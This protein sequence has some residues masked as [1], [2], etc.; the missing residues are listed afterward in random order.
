MVAPQGRVRRPPASSQIGD[1]RAPGEPGPDPGPDADG[2]VL[3]P[4]QVAGLLGG[5]I[6]ASYPNPGPGSPVAYGPRDPATVLMARG[7][8]VALRDGA[9]HLDGE[10]ATPEMLASRAARPGP[11]GPGAGR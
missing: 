9:Y 6:I 7:H 5:R 4:G 1:A 11:A 10:P 3:T 8:R 2:P